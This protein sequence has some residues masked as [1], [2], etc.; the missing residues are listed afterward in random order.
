MKWE[1]VSDVKPSG[2]IVVYR[3]QGFYVGIVDDSSEYI[4]G[5]NLPEGYLG[6]MPDDLWLSIRMP[7]SGD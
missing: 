1:K 5:K 6:L 2:L 7:V 3:W 4:T